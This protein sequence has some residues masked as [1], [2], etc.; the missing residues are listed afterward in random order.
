MYVCIVV[1]IGL[2]HPAYLVCVSCCKSVQCIS[3]HCRLPVPRRRARA[4]SSEVATAYSVGLT[5]VTT[6]ELLQ[7]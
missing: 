2:Y 1:V 7:A 6:D 4:K 3:N 5:P